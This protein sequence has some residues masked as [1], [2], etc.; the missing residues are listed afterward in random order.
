V[1][2]S[3]TDNRYQKLMAEYEEGKRDSVMLRR[4]TLMSLRS[5]DQ[6]NATKLGNDFITTMTHPLS[7]SNLTFIK[8]TIKTSKD[9]GFEMFWTQRQ[10]VD[11]ILGE[12]SALTKINEII[13]AEEI[14]PLIKTKPNWDSIQQVVI[15]KYGDIGEELVYGRQMVF[16][17][18]EAN[19]INW[20][21]YAKYYVLYFQKAMTHPKYQ[22]NNMSWNIFEHVNDTETLEFAVR[23]MKYSI[24]KW[25][26]NNI[27]A[28]D[29]YANLLH[30]LKKS[31]EAIQWEEKALKLKK[32][33]P[34]EKVFAETLQKMKA[35]LPT[36]PQTQ[37]N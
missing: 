1:D 24:E 34:D 33:A 5:K 20:E 2:I 8:K 10:Q 15:K 25:D 7:K 22:I 16:Y 37:N 31:G 29:T 21:K 27:E 17:G 14:T 32:G 30:K 36:W 13:E 35:G 19:P 18:F 9:K 26:Q 12:N 3:D 6:E 23:L 28:Y 11:S 4:L